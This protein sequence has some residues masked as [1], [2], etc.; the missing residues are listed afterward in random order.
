MNRSHLARRILLTAVA[1]LIWL[2]LA[3]CLFEPRTPELPSSGQDIPYLPQTSPINVWENL[4]TAL[5]YSDSFG[6]EN[7]I[8]E[9]FVYIP[10][11]DT[12][13]QYPG[14]FVDWGKEREMSFISNFFNSGSTN[15]AEMRN[16]EFVVP[17]PGGTEAR[18]EGVIYYLRVQEAGNGGET[19]FRASAIINFVLDGND[20][21][22]N[23]WEDQVGEDD[24]DTGQPLPTMGV[25]RATF[26]SN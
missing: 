1:A 2:P 15:I 18:W 17:D 20:W 21:Y 4:Q 11:S 7:N 5:N 8:H 25:L 16:T 9:D 23:R 14:V 12:Q 10:D 19:R 24:P 13:S 26:G 3:G 6:W 22:V